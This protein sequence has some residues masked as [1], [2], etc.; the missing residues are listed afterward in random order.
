[1]LTYFR[2]FTWNNV[3]RCFYLDC[4]ISTDWNV[5]VS[6]IS[7][8]YI[9]CLLD[10]WTKCSYQTRVKDR[11]AWT[12]KKLIK[13]D[14]SGQNCALLYSS[15]AGSGLYNINGCWMG[16]YQTAET[17]SRAGSLLSFEHPYYHSDCD[18]VLFQDMDRKRFAVNGLCRQFTQD[19][20]STL[21]LHQ[22]HI[23]LQ[24]NCLH[25]IFPP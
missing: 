18:C 19:K 3:D 4:N 22:G 20:V 14:I 11:D 21:H 13:R 5:D 9:F 15:R 10:K 16:F 23:E 25:F 8:S 7:L 12:G 24:K 6:H 2:Y 17:C 1:M